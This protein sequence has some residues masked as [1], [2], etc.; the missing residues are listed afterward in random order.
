[1]D[2][3]INEFYKRRSIKEEGG[4][5]FKKRTELKLKVSIVSHDDIKVRTDYHKYVKT[6]DPDW[7]QEKKRTERL[8][9]RWVRNFNQ[10]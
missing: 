1:M 8:G 4:T 10:D 5:F 6:K 3:F 9:R 7:K 2:Y